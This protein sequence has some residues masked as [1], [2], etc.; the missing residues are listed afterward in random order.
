MLREALRALMLSPHKE[1]MQALAQNL[2][3]IAKYYVKDRDLKELLEAI[4]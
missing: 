2:D 1:V 3:D 4:A